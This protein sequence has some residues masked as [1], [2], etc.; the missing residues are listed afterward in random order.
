[1]NN[2]QLGSLGERY[3]AK[4]L[5]QQGYKI[6]EKNYKCKSG[7][8][9]IIAS[10]GEELVFVEVKTRTDDPY[11]RGMYAVD[12]RKQEHILRAASCYIEETGSKLQPR[13]D[14]IELQ[15]DSD[16]KVMK[17]NHIKS[18]FFQSGPYSRY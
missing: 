13:M 7:E 12:K 15:L 4:Y 17:V 3:A 5:K 1:M 11:V 9:D 16:K 18:A 6:L 2:K 10:D 8:I 14:V